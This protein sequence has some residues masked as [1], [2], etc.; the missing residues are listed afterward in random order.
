MLHS[1]GRIQLAALFEVLLFR[2]IRLVLGVGMFVL[3]FGRAIVGLCCRFLVVTLKK[4][5]VVLLR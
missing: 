5:L 1:Q 2:D 3:F 4:H